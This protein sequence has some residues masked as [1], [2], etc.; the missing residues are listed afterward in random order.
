[1]V[2]S[3]I[4]GTAIGAFVIGIAIGFFIPSDSDTQEVTQMTVQ[5][6][7]IGY[8]IETLTIGFIPSEK[9]DEL[10]PKA[11]SLARFLESE[12]DDQV[13]IEVVVPSNYETIIEGLR[14][15]HI[16][17]AFMDTGPG[18][19]AHDRANAEVTMAEV[20]KGKVGYYATVWQLSLIHI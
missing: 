1:M 4:I 11:E 10:T 6:E 18:W 15:G 12:F 9:A 16:D 19:I 13:E 14:F 2:K 3:A 5:Q 20:K 17:A 8:D 7:K